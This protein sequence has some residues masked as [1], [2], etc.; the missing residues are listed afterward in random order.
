MTTLSSIANNHLVL[1][2]RCGHVG[3]IAISGLIEI[4]GGD[5]SVDAIERA[6]RCRRCRTKS[7][8]SMQIIY[9]GSSEI[10]LLG[11]ETKQSGD[12]LDEI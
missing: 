4:H 9:V 2:C 7:I 12:N 6:A 10:A 1:N 5:V 8:T 11:C 3:Q